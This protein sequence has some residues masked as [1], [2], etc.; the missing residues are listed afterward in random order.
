MSDRLDHP[1][2]RAARAAAEAFADGGFVVL[3][4]SRGG[5]SEANLAIAAQFVTPDALAFLSANA[6][7]IVR[8]CLTDE[9][10]AQLGLAPLRTAG[11]GWQPTGAIAHRGASGTGASTRDQARTIQA[12]IDPSCGP[13][14]FT[15]GGYV[16]P[17]RARPGGTLRRAGRTEAAVDLARIAGC[18]PA[19]ALSLLMGDDGAP[20]RG[21]AVVTY[22]EEKGLPFVAVADVIALRRQTER[23]VERITGARLPTVHG[24]F[25][26]VGFRERLTGAHH[27]ALIRGDVAGARDVLVRVHAECLS[28]DV[29]G[30]DACTCA[31]DMRHALDRL[32]EEERGVL[33]YLVGGD[34][35]PGRLSRHERS[36]GD[37]ARAPMD[38]YGIGAQILAELGLTTIRI[39]TNHPKARIPG[40]EGFGLEIVEQVPLVPAGR[41]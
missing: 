10:C 4:E 11:D 17:L 30:S 35:S 24:D 13:D 12:A 18:P 26:A 37:T 39:L 19:A 15:P 38:E 2:P 36:D 5:E 40:L 33:V 1:D 8:L 16:F 41:S 25:T 22:A 27:V 20:L 9:R 21:D 6:H 14:D 34:R 23:L 29:F 32:G 3:C 31:E 28:G 7:G